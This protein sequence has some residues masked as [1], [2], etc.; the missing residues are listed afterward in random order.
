MALELACFIV[1]KQ[2]TS[3]LLFKPLVFCS[4]LYRLW[5]EWKVLMMR[6]HQLLPVCAQVH[7]KGIRRQNDFFK[8]Q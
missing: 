3:Q 8:V 4:L 5:P 1:E 7:D 6:T 2:A